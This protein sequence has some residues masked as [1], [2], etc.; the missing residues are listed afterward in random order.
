[1]ADSKSAKKENVKKTAGSGLP[2]FYR[3]PRPLDS[4]AHKELSLKELGDLGFTS[5]INA[6]P[7]N[8]VEFPQ[9]CHH[10]PIA[11]SPDDNATPVA[12]VGLRDKENLFVDADGQWL[13]NTYIPAYIRR[14]PFIFS[15]LPDSDQL[16]LCV[17]FVEGETIEKGGDRR[18]FDDEGNASELAGNALEFCKSYHAAAQRTIEFSK[19]L[20]KSGLLIDRQ[21]QLSVGDD[22]RINFTGFKIIDEAKLAE[23]DD[24]TFLEWRK[25][26]WLPYLY[27]HLFSGGQ[28][29]NLSRVL[30][31]KIATEKK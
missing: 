9:V 17:D 29:Q 1:M 20:A 4:S 30:A 19:A 31:E 16:T 23:L 12:I 6:V 11:F 27:A 2:L 7:V 24:K 15:E 18:F 25:N 5:E 8:L 14:Y 26:G 3:E 21:A 22:V 10:F 28:W 13:A